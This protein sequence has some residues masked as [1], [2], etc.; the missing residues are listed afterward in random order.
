MLSAVL[1]GK[2]RG[3][4]L[5][6]RD[7]LLGDTEGAEDLLTASVFE[8]L[9]YLP[10]EVFKDVMK[11]LLGEE[12][13]PGTL[14]EITFWPSWYEGK[15]SRRVE[16]DVVLECTERIVIVEAKRYDGCGQQYAYQL[17]GELRAANEKEVARPILLAVG[18]MRNDGKEEA[19]RMRQEV[20]AALNDQYEYNFEYDL[21]FRSWR[22][23]YVS[24]AEAVRK[25]PENSGL[26]R[27][28]KDVEQA[29]DWHG[30]RHQERR[31]LKDLGSVE[32][33]AVEGM[34]SNQLKNNLLD[35]RRAYALLADY[36]Q[37]VIELMGFVCEELGARHDS[38]QLHNAAFAYFDR[39]YSK[40]NAGR[41]FLPFLDVSFL[42]LNAEN[43][44]DAL[45]NHQPG[46]LLI[47]ARVCSNTANCW[48]NFEK[49]LQKEEESKLPQKGRS[50]LRLYVLQCIDPVSVE[51]HW[52]KDVWEYIRYDEF[53]KLMP[54][55]KNEKNYQM[56]AEP[57]DLEELGDEKA[58]RDAMR[59]FKQ[60]VMEAFRP[61]C[62]INRFEIK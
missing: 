47:D 9:A 16:P 7:F 10:D 36:Q 51:H 33:F 17:A 29:Y 62:P 2:R 40:N 34:M 32:S 42:W 45:S 27:I 56:Y 28:L 54:C 4:G 18:G 48:P 13:A 1:N 24:F 14:E 21:V 6:G 57:F 20:S 58:V 49:N 41:S 60:R 44:I 61:K 37:R 43:K 53:D 23:L 39:I 22:Q 8:R 50:E 46:D 11:H 12:N 5:V 3:S 52:Y 15:E 59:G 31:W 26:Q 19:D 35:V 30:V 38:H 55:P 25:R